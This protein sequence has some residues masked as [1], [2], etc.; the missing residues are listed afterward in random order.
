MNERLITDI[1]S[2]VT[3]ILI[4][5]IIIYLTWKGFKFG[6]KLL[7]EKKLLKFTLG[8]LVSVFCFIILLSQVGAVLIRLPK[9]L[10]S[11]IYSHRISQ[12]K[13]DFKD[14]EFICNSGLDA[15]ADKNYG[16]ALAFFKQAHQLGNVPATF[17][18]GFMYHTG[19]GTE[20]DIEKAL[21]YYKEAA[22]NGH[23]ESL[24]ALSTFY[25]KGNFV[26]QDIAKAI[27]YLEI[28]VNKKNAKA[29]WLLA[30]LYEGESGV[31]SVEIGKAKKYL[32]V[33]IKLGHEDAKAELGSI[34]LYEN[35]YLKAKKFLEDAA[36]NKSAEA[37]SYLGR[38]YLFGLGVRRDYKIAFS[39]FEKAAKE[40]CD[41]AKFYQGC[42]YLIG[43][44][45]EQDILKAKNC[46]DD[47]AI[48]FEKSKVML[49]ALNNTNDINFVAE[50]LKT[51]FV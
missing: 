40:G 8:L 48:F 34:Y 35:K 18:I 3:E 26:E 2:I 19:L 28:A 39:Y 24:I 11:L 27:N 21:I 51:A 22:E 45:V 46:F 17:F 36:K 25:L 15:L 32:K 20:V 7:K 23:P 29:A 43:F 4:A 44:G 49:E 37:L 30:K 31:V 16:K 38:M 9:E 33:A 47:S 1:A 12:I 41:L 50:T 42:L 10:S 5:L 13:E 14:S 6:L